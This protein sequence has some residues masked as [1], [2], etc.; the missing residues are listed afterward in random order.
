MVLQYGEELS[1]NGLELCSVELDSAMEM[2]LKKE[3]E[4][5]KAVTF[6]IVVPCHKKCM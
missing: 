6:G 2:R 4:E 3:W 1:S 5:T